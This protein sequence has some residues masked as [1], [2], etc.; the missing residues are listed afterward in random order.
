MRNIATIIR[1]SEKIRKNLN[2]LYYERA[3]CYKF[4]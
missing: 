1:L 3:R 2:I 4:N